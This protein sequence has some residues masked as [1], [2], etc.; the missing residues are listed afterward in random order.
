MIS[1]FKKPKKKKVSLFYAGEG[2]VMRAF[3]IFALPRL[4]I[5]IPEGPHRGGLSPIHVGSLS[6]GI[7]WE[8]GVLK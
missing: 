7:G 5:S 8:H 1:H 4:I 3:Q 6:E 2:P